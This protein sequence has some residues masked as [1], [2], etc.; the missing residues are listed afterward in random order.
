[1]CGA[2]ALRA[3]RTLRDATAASG[4][5]LSVLPGD[6]APTI[7]RLQ[8]EL[9][10]QKRA[11]AAL[12]TELAGFRAQELV[13]S[14]E[15]VTLN[16]P[17]GAGVKLVARAIDADANGLKSLAAAVA[18]QPGHVAALI[19]ATAPALVV[20][21]R[22]SDVAISAQQVLAALVKQFGGKG[23]GRPELAQ[24]GGLAGSAADILAAVRAQLA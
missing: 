13:A 5:L 20:I 22:S 23:G 18:A 8:A 2:R 4:R 6:L 16:A 15:P 24:G 21:A 7:E 14:A 3:H 17:A 9:K 10:D 11:A 19:S 1:V 12:Q